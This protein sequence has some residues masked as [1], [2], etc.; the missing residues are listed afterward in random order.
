ME[1]VELGSSGA[2]VID[3]LEPSE[4]VGERVAPGDKRPSNHQ[5]AALR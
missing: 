5:H 4:H 1:T 2:V 3:E